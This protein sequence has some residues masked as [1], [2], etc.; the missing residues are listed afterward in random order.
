[1][2]APAFALISVLMLELSNSH[3]Q[4]DAAIEALEGSVDHWIEYYSKERGTVEPAAAADDVGSSTIPGEEEGANPS[5][6]DY[7]A[8]GA[9]SDSVQRPSSSDR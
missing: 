8:P 7:A 3:A 9:A 5:R 6:S 1:M 4:V 2:N